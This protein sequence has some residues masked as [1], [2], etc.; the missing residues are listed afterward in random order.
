MSKAFT[1]E[2]DGDDDDEVGLPPL[3][4]GGKNY[5]TPQG[6]ERLKTEL[7]DLIDN[8]RPRIVEIVPVSYTHL[9]LP[10]IYSV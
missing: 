9:T 7:L 6:F 8:E 3:P 10:T 1:K 2:S 5:I 4:P